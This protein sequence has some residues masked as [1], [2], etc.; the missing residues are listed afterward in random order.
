M[1]DDASKGV[2]RRWVKRDGKLSRRV[3]STAE[4]EALLE[5]MREIKKKYGCINDMMGRS[6]FGWNPTTNTIDTKDD[7]FDN[8]AKIDSFAK[9]LR[10]K[11]FPYYAQ[12]CEVFE[13]DRATGECCID[14]ILAPWNSSTTVETERSENVPIT[15]EYYVSTPD[16]NLYGDDE[17]FMNSFAFAIAPVNVNRSETERVSSR[18]RKMVATDIG[19]KFDEKFEAFVNVTDCRLGDIAN[20]F[21]IEAEESQA[22]KQVWS[23]VD[24]INDLTIEDKC[25]VSRKIVNNKAD[26]DLFLSMTA[27]GKETF[28]KMLAAGLGSGSNSVD[29]GLS[30]SRYGGR[31][32]AFP[33]AASWEIICWSIWGARNKMLFEN[34]SIT[35][36]TLLLKARRL[37]QVFR[38]PDLSMVVPD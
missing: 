13:K 15:L 8:F 6:G 27:A 38:R 34:C 37:H 11:S 33:K 9:M 3:W 22:R 26:L 31:L 29:G 4:E 28:V 19:D 30:V 7:A 2:R 1:D 23:V 5:C 17:E 14:P 36:D 10:F 25:L 18:K 32:A 35:T 12:W 20:R 21:G 16:P 24:S